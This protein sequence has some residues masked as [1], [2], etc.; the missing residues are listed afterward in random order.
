MNEM[1]A[2]LLKDEKNVLIN[3]QEGKTNAMRQWRMSSKDEINQT[4]IKEYI[5]ESCKNVDEGKEIKPQKKPLVIPDLLQKAL[6]KDSE[7]LKAFEAFSLS[8]KREYANHISEAKREVTK[9]KRLEAL[10]NASS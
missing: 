9:Q 1:N 6:E 8:H 4:L 2:N 3:A 10:V 5:L 7:L